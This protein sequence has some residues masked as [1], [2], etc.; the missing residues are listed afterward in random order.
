MMNVIMYNCYFVDITGADNIMGVDIMG[1]TLCEV[2]IMNRD[3]L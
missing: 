3:I 1:V 2:D